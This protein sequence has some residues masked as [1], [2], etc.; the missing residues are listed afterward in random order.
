M[1]ESE[2]DFSPEK[3][4]GGKDVPPTLTTWYNLP[5]LEVSEGG[6]VFAELYYDDDTVVPCIRISASREFQGSSFVQPD[7]MNPFGHRA[8]REAPEHITSLQI[9]CQEL[10]GIDPGEPPNYSYYRYSADD[11]DPH[12]G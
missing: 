10:F 5:F 9:L 3:R 6:E 1:R 2:A 11:P 12:A 7:E 8:E 4:G